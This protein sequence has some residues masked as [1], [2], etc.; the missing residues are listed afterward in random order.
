MIRIDINTEEALEM[1]EDIEDYT[2]NELHLDSRESQLLGII[3]QLAMIIRALY[4]QGNK[5]N[6]CDATKS[7]TH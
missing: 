7:D 4:L 1:L 6:E 3:S 2:A 5:D